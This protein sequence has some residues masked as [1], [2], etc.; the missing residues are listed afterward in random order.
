MREAEGDLPYREEDKVSVEVWMRML[1]IDVLNKQF[2][3][4]GS[5]TVWCV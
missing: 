2:P 3:V 5:G 4:S 1:C